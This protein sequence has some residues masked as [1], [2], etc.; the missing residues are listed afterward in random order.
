MYVGEL[1][2]E[3]GKNKNSSTYPMAYLNVNNAVNI[4]VTR[5]IMGAT[6]LGTHHSVIYPIVNNASRIIRENAPVNMVIWI[7]QRFARSSWPKIIQV[8]MG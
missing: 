7:R 4:A 6:R 1:Y 5:L 2:G 3:D 8:S